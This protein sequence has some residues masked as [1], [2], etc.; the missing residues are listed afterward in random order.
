MQNQ[1]ATGKTT[2]FGG[3]PNAH[4]GTLDP[5]GYI[6]REQRRSG[7]AAVALARQKGTNK[8]TIAPPPSPVGTEPV[9][10]KFN[11]AGLF[12]SGTGKIGRL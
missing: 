1:Y 2:Y 12:I 4:S 10:K 11:K 7:L 3:L 9:K 6:Q 8:P 5:S